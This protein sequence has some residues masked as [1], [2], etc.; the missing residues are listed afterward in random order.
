M[1]LTIS[2][3]TPLHI[4]RYK[5]LQDTGEKISYNYTT[6]KDF[7]TK[8]TTKYK[9]TMRH[10]QKSEILLYVCLST[11]SLICFIFFTALV[12]ADTLRSLDFDLTVHLQNHTPLR[13]DD[14]FS[15]L[16]I[17]GRFEFTFTLLLVLL[18]VNRKVIGAIVVVAAFGIAHI[19]EVIGKSLLHQPGPPDMFLRTHFTDF[20]G[21]YVHTNASY[22]SGHSLRIIFILIIVV[23]LVL[24]SKKVP[25]LGKIG[26]IFLSLGFAS[27]MLISRVSLGEHWT[28]DVIGGVFLG[29]AAAFASA[30]FL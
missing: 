3:C 14:Y 4:R 21:L 11:F 24:I 16:S 9:Y 10:K 13:L 5:Y 19:I 26:A 6:M 29:A 1:V 18:L 15:L 17:V 30:I 7:Y 20:P 28:T 22:P 27:A 25:K 23:Y 12:R 2:N 8:F